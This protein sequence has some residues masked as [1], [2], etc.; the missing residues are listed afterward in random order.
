MLTA[1]S[2]KK[3]IDVMGH[4]SAKNSTY[5]G[6]R[7]TTP[8]KL[9][10]YNAIALRLKTATYQM[11][12]VATP[13]P[14]AMEGIMKEFGSLPT[15]LTDAERSAWY[16]ASHLTRAYHGLASVISEASSETV[17]MSTD[18]RIMAILD[19]IG[20]VS[21]SNLKD[22]TK[23][24]KK[25][26]RFAPW[27]MWGQD[28]RLKWED[29]QN[30]KTGIYMIPKKSNYGFVSKEPITIGGGEEISIAKGVMDAS[31]ISVMGLFHAFN[32]AASEMLGIGFDETNLSTPF[33]YFHKML[34]QRVVPF[35]AMYMGYSVADRLAD[36]YMDGTPFGEGLTTFGANVLAG[37]RVGA[38]GFLDMTGITGIAADMEDVMPGIITSPA[39]GILRGVGPIG[40]GMSMGAKM[41]GPSGA[42][43]GGIIGSAIG[44]L[45]GGGPLGAFGMWD[46]SKSRNEVVQELIGEKQVEVRKGRWW[47]LSSSPFEGTRVQYYRPH[48][49][50]LLRSDYKEAPGFKDSM[51]TE[52]IGHIAP[53]W[54]AM[55]DYYTRPYPVTAGLFS[56]LPV[57]G[58][59]FDLMS[60][61]SKELRML[62]L[63]G[64]PMHRGEASPLY[65]QRMGEETG[66]STGEVASNF[67]SHEGYFAPTEGSTGQPMGTYTSPIKGAE[68]VQVGV[69]PN[70]TSSPMMRSSFEWGLGET[71][72]NVKDIVGI[73]GFL[74]GSAFEGMTGRRGLFDYA[75]ELA[76]PVEIPG[77][78]REYWDYELGGILGM[79]EIIR[80]YINP[81]RNQVEIYNPIRNTMPTWLPGH[82]YYIDFQHGDPFTTVPMG[83]SRL[84]GASYETLHD[85]DLTMPIVGEILGENTDSQIAFFMGI[86]NYM[87]ARNR[88]IDIA[89]EVAIGY[90]EDAKRYGELISEEKTIYNV[91]LNTSATVDA[92]VT[93]GGTGSAIP[94]RIVPKGFAGQS[95]LN[96]FL[97]M[98]GV[99]EGLLIEMD[100]ESGG[101]S[102]R[103]VRKDVKKFVKQLKAATGAK[104][105]AYNQIV[106]FEEN[107]RAFN[108][109]N[110]YSWFDRFKILAD[111][112]HYS[113]EY[114]RAKS[115]VKKQI[116][117][118]KLPPGKI[119][120]F[121]MIEEQVET[122][123]KAY[124]FSEYRFKDLGEGLTPYT[125]ARDRFIEEEYSG[126]EK[127]MGSIWEQATHIRNPLQTKFYHNLDALEE[128]ERN[129][130]YGKSLKMWQNP[131]ED[132]VKSY[133]LSAVGE[134][135]PV[136]ASVNWATAGFMIGGGPLASMAATAGGVFTSIA[137]IGNNAFIPE[138]TE[139]VRDV[140]SQTDAVKYAKYMKLYQETGNEEYLSMAK[141]TITGKAMAGQPLTA[142]SIGRSLG[143]PEKDY[144]ED[145]INNITRS[146]MRRATQI[147]PA[148]AVASVY[149]SMG[150][151][152]Y[153]EDLMRS[154]ARE[155]K[156]R[157][158]PGSDAS[159]YS[160]DIPISVPAITSFEQEGLNAHDAGYGWYSQMAQIERLKSMDVYRGEGVYGDFESR[161]SM[162]RFDRS[163]DETQSLR[164]ALSRFGS[165]VNVMDDG[166]N[167]IEVEIVVR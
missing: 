56:N 2:G 48:I 89:R 109:A 5:F 158:V 34:A 126:L 128:Y 91:N 76:S 110:S 95:D 135:D 86:P 28:S 147:L 84:P 24:Y 78:Q 118:G 25:R 55:K 151:T 59:M 103:I 41:A 159:I 121:K 6:M 100:P 32:R 136:Q 14:R 88:A 97:V 140:V 39:S 27:A 54:Y 164:R 90:R 162:K 73:R 30:V 8:N 94:V 112:A 16:A 71:V 85:V 62:T 145:I 22:I 35:T 69:G 33:Q 161:V 17:G 132:W 107:R 50:S 7:P 12:Y 167:R 131:Y 75:P 80:R 29:T 72:E 156:E 81:K 4:I 160:P 101:L 120:E 134:H 143:R 38:Q 127:F 36:R 139:N 74:M 125:R 40:L 53:D 152:G 124:E 47:E 64:I 113:Q 102:D 87:S 23:Y 49:Y 153:A 15:P 60:S 20:N 65:T 105:M 19:D 13:N 111:V 26:K 119:A 163:L 130:I 108:L 51:F 70:Y 116:D 77:V 141:R 137:S 96:S 98:S 21:G 99:E 117:A 106:D 66:F 144:I 3:V 166:Q 146:N 154:Y 43:T 115:I 11:G 155:Q 92:I 42:L 58:N 149:N 44:M 114:R 31:N 138:R 93:R 129:S 45:A 157:Y 67:V 18:S 82:N 61:T 165:N 68:P 148:P 133:F 37:A 150:Q 142:R 57:F 10:E 52:M 123:K 83:E 1:P 104:T 46:I 9:D 79:S 63:R 122:K